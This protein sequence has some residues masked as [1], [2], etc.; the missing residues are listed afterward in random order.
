MPV[1]GGFV[2]IAAVSI[3]GALMFGAIGMLMGS[4]VRTFE[5][6]SGLMNLISVPMWVLSGVFFSASNFPAAV[7]PIIQLLPLTA[8]VDALRAVVLEGA[9]LGGVWHELAIIA[10]WTIV[11]FALALKI[12][13]WR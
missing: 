3:G 4:R 5:G 9:T 1:Q 13:K 10:S 12:F 11:P 8:L 7:Q 6:A 2:A